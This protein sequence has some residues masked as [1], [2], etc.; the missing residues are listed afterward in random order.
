MSPATPRPAGAAGSAGDGRRARGFGRL[1]RRVPG[2]RRVRRAF[3]VLHYL[4]VEVSAMFGAAWRRSLQLRVTVS[5][6]A[7]CSGVVVVLGL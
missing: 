1:L 5:T 3:R 7:L 4:A 2:A 6:L